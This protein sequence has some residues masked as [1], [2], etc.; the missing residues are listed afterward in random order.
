MENFAV[1][2][3]DEMYWF[4]GKKPRP[5]ARENVYVMTM[6][7]RNPR[8]IVGF[9]VASAAARARGVHMG[10]PVKRPPEDFAKLARLW[11]LGELK[12]VDLMRQTGLKETT[13]YRRLREYRVFRGK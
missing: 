11:A 7:S 10:R 5:Q 2:E 1:L 6:V 12:T 13:L 4:V 3:L 9:D 8:Q